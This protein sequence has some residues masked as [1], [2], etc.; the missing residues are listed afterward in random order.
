MAVT[1]DD[2]DG[3]GGCGRGGAG[4]GIRISL[5]WIDG[6]GDDHISDI[7]GVIYLDSRHAVNQ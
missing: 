5:C 7:L 6:L 4:G 2:S 3:S 1:T